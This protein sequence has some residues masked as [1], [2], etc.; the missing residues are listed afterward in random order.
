MSGATTGKLYINNDIP[1]E[2][3]GL[4]NPEVSN[5]LITDATVTVNIIDSDGTAVGTEITLTY[6]TTHNHYFGVADAALPFIENEKYTFIYTVVAPGG[7]DAEWRNTV[8]AE[9]RTS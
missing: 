8:T 6:D 9:Y 7:L 5:D 2:V 1:L 4:Y 3:D